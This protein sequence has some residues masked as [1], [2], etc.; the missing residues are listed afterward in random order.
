MDLWLL[1]TGE[2]V[3]EKG[4]IKAS[5]GGQ[6]ERNIRLFFFLL[7]WY[8]YNFMLSKVTEWCAQTKFYLL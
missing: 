3:D 7:W 5:G 2:R 8:L 1:V 6:P 4:S